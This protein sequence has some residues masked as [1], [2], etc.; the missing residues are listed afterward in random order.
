MPCCADVRPTTSSL[1]K[2][3]GRRTHNQLCVGAEQAKGS[4]ASCAGHRHFC[5]RTHNR[6][7]GE[8]TVEGAPA[9]SR[10]PPAT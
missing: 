6:V 10:F 3:S 8:F 2:H 4:C 5:A 1:H 7:P 9:A